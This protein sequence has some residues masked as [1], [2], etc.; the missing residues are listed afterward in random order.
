MSSRGVNITSI[1]IYNHIPEQWSEKVLLWPTDH[2]NGLEIVTRYW[3]KNATP[4][5]ATK[6]YI[7]GRFVEILMVHF[8]NHF[9]KLEVS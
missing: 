2:T 6:G 3:S 9:S 8:K 1:S 4:D 5:E 7:I